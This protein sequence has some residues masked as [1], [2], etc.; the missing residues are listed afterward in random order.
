MVAKLLCGFGE[1]HEKEYRIVKVGLMVVT[2]DDELAMWFRRMRQDYRG[3]RVTRVY[4]DRQIDAVEYTI[5]GALFKGDFDRVRQLV[6]LA[7]TN[8]P[9]LTN[10]LRYTSWRWRVESYRLYKQFADNPLETIRQLKS[11]YN[12]YAVRLGDGPLVQYYQRRYDALWQ[13]YR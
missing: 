10:T 12:N 5:F 2:N 9:S 4:T 7:L 13:Q 1:W 11:H 8:N 3:N 6:R